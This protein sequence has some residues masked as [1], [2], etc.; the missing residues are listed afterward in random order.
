MMRE[1]AARLRGVPD[2]GKQGKWAKWLL[3]H[4]YTV[5][6]CVECLDEMLAEL[7]DP[8]H[9]REGKVDW[10]VVASN[11]SAWKLKREGMEAHGKPDVRSQ[12]GSGGNP[13]QTGGG[14]VS[15]DEQRIA[16]LGRQSPESILGVPRASTLDGR[17]P[18]RK[19]APASGGDYDAG[20]TAVHFR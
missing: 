16:A 15:R 11:I 3:D 14:R 6:E 4:D 13:P 9:W 17:E 5:G 19:A 1:L 12:N 18:D 20:R 10:A 7:K 8:V 2:G